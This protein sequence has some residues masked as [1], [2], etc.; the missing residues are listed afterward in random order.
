VGSVASVGLERERRRRYN[1]VRRKSSTPVVIFAGQIW[2]AVWPWQSRKRERE[3]ERER[4]RGVG[5]WSG[6]RRKEKEKEKEKEK[7][8]KK[9][10]GGVGGFNKWVFNRSNYWVHMR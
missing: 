3:R 5:K 10:G 9:G 4:E 2:L 6:G 1:V 7:K 8:K